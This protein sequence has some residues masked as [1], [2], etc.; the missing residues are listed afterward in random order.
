MRTDKEYWRGKIQLILKHKLHGMDISFDD[1]LTDLSQYNNKHSQIT[2][3][4]LWY[5]INKDRTRFQVVAH[6]DATEPTGATFSS[7]WRSP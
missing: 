4:L 7:T 6:V 2:S 3:G 1:L 5:I